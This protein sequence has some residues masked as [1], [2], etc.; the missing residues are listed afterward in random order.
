MKLHNQVQDT[1]MSDGSN[2]AF[3]AVEAGISVGTPCHMCHIS[4]LCVLCGGKYE[5]AKFLSAQNLG[6]KFYT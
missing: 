4:D 3:G 1:E 6:H 5:F 2:V